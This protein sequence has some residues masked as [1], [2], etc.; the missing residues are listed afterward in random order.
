[1]GKDKPEVL[2]PMQKALR[3]RENKSASDQ[4]EIYIE[5]IDPPKKHDRSSYSEE[6]IYS[7]AKNIEETKLL[8]PII[9]RKKDDGRYERIAGFRR[10]EAHKVLKREKIKAI[11]VDVTDEVAA[12]MM[13]SENLQRE[14]LNPYDELVALINLA[15]Q[16]LNMTEEE[17]KAFIY[18][19]KNFKSGNVSNHSREDAESLNKLNEVLTKVGKMTYDGIINRLRMLQLPEQIKNAIRHKGLSYLVGIELAKFKD[20]EDFESIIERATSEKMSVREVKSLYAERMSKSTVVVKN[21]FKINTMTDKAWN[22][23]D[24]E[25]KQ[26]IAEKFADIQKILAK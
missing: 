6:A 3:E 17:L 4:D 7:L 13:L 26:L 19:I 2:T 12:L 21:P 8:S 15:A 5:L 10:I 23:L 1:M 20:M 22:L 14:N 25:Q 9:V 18:R 24:D 16:Y 11:I